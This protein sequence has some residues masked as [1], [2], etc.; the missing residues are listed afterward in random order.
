MRPRSP[1]LPLLALYGALA[2]GALAVAAT[3]GRGPGELVELADGDAWLDVHGPAAHVLSAGLGLVLAGGTL[4]LTRALVRRSGWA[5]ALHLEL[6]P[7]VHAAGDAALA[8]RG[9]GSAVAE[10]LVFRAL[11]VPLVGLWVASVAFGAVHLLHGG[12][13]SARSWA[14]SA[15]VMGL[16]FGTLYLATGSLL[17]PIV[18]HATINVANLRFLRDTELAPTRSRRLGGL[19]AR[20]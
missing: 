2:L 16:L 9:V 11:L 6:R 20:G 17:G 19:L 15:A 7:S 12:G 13:R 18:A 1:S 14:A 5:R 4:L 3:T 8:L 10:E